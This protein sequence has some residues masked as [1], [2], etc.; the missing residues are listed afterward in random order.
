MGWNLSRG[1]PQIRKLPT[2]RRFHLRIQAEQK[3]KQ[4]IDNGALYQHFHNTLTHI[5]GLALAPLRGIAAQRVS[6]GAMRPG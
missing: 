6:P 1:I 5:H 4:A 3:C 2:I